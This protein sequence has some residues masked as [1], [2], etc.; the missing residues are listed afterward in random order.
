MPVT[1]LLLGVLTACGG[2]EPAAAPPPPAGQAAGKQGPA[3]LPEATTYTRVA[4]APRD[5]GT[6]AANSVIRVLKK[7]V[8]YDR[9][10]GKPVAMLP[11]TQLGA[12]TWVPVVET[13]GEWRRV[14]LPSRP[15]GTSGWVRPAEGTVRS[16][17]TP[18][19]VRVELGARRLR[20][21]NGR[22][23]VGT[24]KVAVGTA[25][26]PT[27]TGRTFLLAVLKPQRGGYSPLIMPLGSHSNTL[28][29][30]G[31]GPGTVG[32]HGWP[33]AKV[34]GQAVTHGCVR[35]PSDALR[36]LAKVPLGSPVLVT[37]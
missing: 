25:K 37:A 27:P 22:T 4:G 34:F 23:T 26:H 14:L 10:D 28:E 21:T 16:A 32:L 15:N 6:T 18:Y 31:G 12:P 33:D 1:A 30:F 35:V 5:T 8:V 13:S 2:E 36:A 3:K 24:W 20:L 19:A 9:P 17:K 7:Q 29:T 11:I